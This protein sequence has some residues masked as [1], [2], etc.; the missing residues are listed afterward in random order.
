MNSRVQSVKNDALIIASFSLLIMICAAPACAATGSWNETRRSGEIARAEG[1]FQDARHSFAAALDQASFDAGDLRRAD[2]DDELAG[3]CA[4]LGD[5]EEAERLYVDALN[6]LEKHPDDGNDVRSAVLSGLAIFRGTQSRFDEAARLLEKAMLSA[7]LAFGQNDVRVAALQSDLGQIYMMQGKVTDAESL[8]QSALKV[9]RKGP[10]TPDRVLSECSLGAVYTMAGRYAEAEPILQEASE[11][12][13]RLGESRPAYAG[14]LVTL[15]DLYR[16]EGKSARGE[17]LLRRAQAI[18]EAALGP[19]ASRVAEVMLDRST[20]ALVSK[21]FSLAE[22]E[23]DQALAILRK[24]NGQG[25]PTVVLN[26][27]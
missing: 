27:I 13:R 5:P 1:R 14:T 10:S 12:S 4:I 8:L 19:E 6:I 21:K 25:Y 2:L 11:E 17:P 23:I 16:L 24:E 9:Q 7:R 3:M 18:Y 26:S 20:D 22:A 15:A